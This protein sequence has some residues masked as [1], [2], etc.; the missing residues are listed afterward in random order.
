MTQFGAKMTFLWNKQVYR[1][2]FVLKTNF[3]N[4]FYVFNLLWTGPQ[5]PERSGGYA[6]KILGSVNSVCG[7]RVGFL[8]AEG[9]LCKHARL[10]GYGASLTARS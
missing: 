10:K 5:N 8:K 3:Y 6:N 2:V 1:I 7:R 4:Y 9:L